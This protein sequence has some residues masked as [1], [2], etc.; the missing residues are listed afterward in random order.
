VAID[1]AA[2]AAGKQDCEDGERKESSRHGR[3]VLPDRAPINP[4]TAIL[5]R[6]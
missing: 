3:M 2:I 1:G 5:E 6:C 4:T